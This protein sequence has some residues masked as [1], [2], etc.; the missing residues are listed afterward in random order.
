M[1]FKIGD[2]VR[3]VAGFGYHAISCGAGWVQGMEFIVAGTRDGTGTTIYFPAD[4]SG[5][6]EEA[7][8]LVESKMETKLK[9]GDKVKYVYCDYRNNPTSLKIGD[10][11]I[12]A[13]V[14]ES[15]AEVKFPALGNNFYM[16]NSEIKLIEPEMPKAKRTFTNS[17]K[18]RLRLKV[19]FDAN[20][21]GF[22]EFEEFYTAFT[23]AML[24]NIEFLATMFIK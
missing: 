24:D 6:Y 8:Q 14:L 19:Y 5:V 17:Q 2:R 15:G 3:C 22:D 1:K 9:V 4:G 11:G 13:D 7:L 21:T 16:K 10:T 18:I 20:D 23:D 12:V